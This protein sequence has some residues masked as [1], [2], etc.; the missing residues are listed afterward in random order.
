MFPRVQ[1]WNKRTTAGIAIS[2][3]WFVG[4][5]LIGEQGDLTPEASRMLAIF[6]AAVVLWVTEA[7]PLAATS[8][9]VILAEILLISDEAL[10]TT[11]S[12]GYEPPP[13]ASIYAAL[14]NP[15]LM[16]FLGGFVLA[17]AASKY[18]LDRNLASVLLRPFGTSPKLVIAGMMSIT[19]VMSMFM[20]NTATTAAMMAVV[21][22]VAAGLT[23]PGTKAA[24]VLAVPVAANV[25][26]I[27]TPIGSPPNAIAL[28][29]LSEEGIDVDFLKWMVLAVPLA[30][31]VLV[32]AWFFLTRRVGEDA[33]DVRIEVGGAFETSTAAV[34]L[35]VT[36]AG[37]VVIWLTESVH[38]IPSSIT[39]FLPVVILL[40]TQV[41]STD[42]L[43][44]LNWHV[45]WLVGGGIALGSGVG[46]TGLDEWFVGLFDWSSFSTLLL[47]A[48]L[49]VLAITLSTVIS[50]SATAN[51]L[52]PIG[53]SLAL[54]G[55]A[56]LDPVL[57]GV[58]IALAC[59]LA[60]ALPVSTPPNAVAYASGYIE[61][62]DLATVGLAVGAVGIILLLF[63]AA[64]I[65]DAT[66]L[67]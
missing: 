40:S 22:P 3:I 27:G 41:F 9:G 8:I 60:M 47:T 58:V 51:L 46:T 14:A 45:L 53:V 38:G 34:I 24:L 10:I 56:D 55:A 21:L 59:S 61:T 54:S 18:H 48:I 36:F 35:Y 12:D 5:L 6:G 4:V 11:A 13:F 29:R 42:D 37:T 28:G 49:A 33:P 32:A 25:G 30:L 63:V 15:T 57:A 65:W 17:E 23:D 64:P 1:S 52:V 43:R 50:N 19:A 16:L 20:S 31:V 62:R 2:T 66:G 44:R 39:G 26:G 67:L 7:I